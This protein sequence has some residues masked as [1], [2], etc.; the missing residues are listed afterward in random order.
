[1]LLIIHFK[2]NR[3][4][5][6][7]PFGSSPCLNLTMLGRQLK[8]TV[9][10]ITKQTRFTTKKLFVIVNYMCFRKTL[11]L[12]IEQEAGSRACKNWDVWK[13]ILIWVVFDVNCYSLV[14]LQMNDIQLKTSADTRLSSRG[15]TTGEKRGRYRPQEKG[16]VLNLLFIS[17]RDKNVV[18]IVI[19]CEI[20]KCLHMDFSIILNLWILLLERTFHIYI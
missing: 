9:T 17:G 16:Y 1:M 10:L 15:Y 13:I 19:E 20:F 11:F 18:W 4:A 12:F 3:S 5:I 6:N 7:S 2:T 14:V 8:C